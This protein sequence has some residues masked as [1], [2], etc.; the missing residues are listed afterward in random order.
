VVVRPRPV[1][2]E[3][4]GCSGAGET[5]EQN[6]RG[7]DAPAETSRRASWS[8]VAAAALG[9]KGRIVGADM[10]ACR[11]GARARTSL[12]LRGVEDPTLGTRA[13]ETVGVGVVY[14]G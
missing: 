2:A 12:E 1:P 8:L 13:Q 4:A 10:S 7:R 11:C 5:G 3:E 6:H 14:A 9:S